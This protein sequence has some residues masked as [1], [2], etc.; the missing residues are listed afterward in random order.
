[1]PEVYASAPLAMDRGLP[2]GNS[3]DAQ[4]RRALHT[5][6]TSGRLVTEV[7]DEI[8][9]AYPSATQEVYTYFL[10]S[11]LV[12][13]VTVDYTTSSKDFIISAVKT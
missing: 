13:T 12:A 1:M 2:V 10:N 6:I 9:A 7:F 3:E 8:Q 11:V 5:K 4:G